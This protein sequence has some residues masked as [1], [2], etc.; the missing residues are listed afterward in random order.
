MKPRGEFFSRAE[1]YALGFDEEAGR[2]YASFPVNYGAVGYGEY[3]ELTENPYRLCMT[4]KALASAF[5]AGCRRHEHDNLLL[6]KP[7][8]N[9]GIPS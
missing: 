2:F 3:Y 5:V 9:R 6:E 8:W 4:D 7:G 1:R